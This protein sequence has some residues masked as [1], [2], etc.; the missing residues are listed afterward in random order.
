MLLNLL[1]FKTISNNIHT[2]T[3][4]SALDID[5]AI[6]FPPSPNDI[7]SFTTDPVPN[8]NAI[9][10]IHADSHLDTNSAVLNLPTSTPMIN[11][12]AFISCDDFLVEFNFNLNQSQFYS[13]TNKSFDHIIS[14][15]LNKDDYLAAN[16]LNELISWSKNEPY[17]IPD[18]LTIPFKGISKSKSLLTD[19]KIDTRKNQINKSIIRI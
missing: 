5:F 3:I 15:N 11:F 8:I 12:H 17:L 4:N 14:R 6:M 2:L 7:S 13:Y 16:I 18:N 1:L 10:P 9:N 19:N